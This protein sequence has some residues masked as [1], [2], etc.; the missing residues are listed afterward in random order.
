MDSPIFLFR[1]DLS[2]VADVPIVGCGDARAI[3]RVQSNSPEQFERS[4]TWGRAVL[5]LAGTP[6]LELRVHDGLGWDLERM[7]LVVAPLDS[8]GFPLPDGDCQLHLGDAIFRITPSVAIRLIAGGTA[9]SDAR[10]EMGFPP[11]FW[12]R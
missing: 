3:L 6:I 1:P 5:L 4:G 2:P 8:D 11:P 10:P 12:R 7:H 9:R